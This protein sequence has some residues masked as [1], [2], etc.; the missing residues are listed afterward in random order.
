MQK[1]LPEKHFIFFPRKLL[2]IQKIVVLLQ[3]F[4]KK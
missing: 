2:H 1:R 3:H 4:S